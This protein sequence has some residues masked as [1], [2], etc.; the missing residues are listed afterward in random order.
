MARGPLSKF[1]WLCFAWLKAKPTRKST[2]IKRSFV[3]RW[4]NYCYGVKVRTIMHSKCVSALLSYLPSMQLACAVLYG[5]L[6]PVWL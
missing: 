3:A 1:C 4:R 6:W 5:Y 2:Y